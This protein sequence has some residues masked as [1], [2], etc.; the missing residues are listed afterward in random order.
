MGAG[1]GVGWDS[2]ARSATMYLNHGACKA[3]ME[4]HSSVG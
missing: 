2:H 1:E 3:G 4:S